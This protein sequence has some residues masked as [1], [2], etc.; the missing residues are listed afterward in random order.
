[1]TEKKKQGSMEYNYIRK[2]FTFNG[3]RYEVT[4][5]TEKE[6]TRK[7][8]DKRASLEH[9]EAL[10]HGEMLLKDWALVAFETF[11]PNI[12]PGS[13]QQIKYRFDKHVISQIGDMRLSRIRPIDCQKIMNAQAGKSKNHIDRVAQELFFVFDCARKNGMISENPAADLAKPQGYKNLRR[14]M[15][16]EERKHFLL[17]AEKVPRFILFELMLYCGCRPME[18][19]GV[20]FEDISRR[21]GVP[22][23]HIRGTKTA[24]SDRF[25]PLPKELQG[26]LCKRDSRGPC[27]LTGRGTMYNDTSYKRLVKRLRREMNISMGA[28]LYRNALVPPLPLADDFVPYILRH[29]YCCDLKKKGIDIRIA[30]QLMGHADI[31]TT[32]NIYD[33]A[34]DESL[35]TAARKMGL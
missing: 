5:K 15:T 29:T 20:C 19:A 25:V 31:R 24:N 4:G 12:T 14:A 13:A 35:M 7:L 34:D 16:D 10:R 21:D 22:F 1:M 33:H 11:K 6:A 2:T 23:L 8:L 32:A 9:E 3:K 26:R 27:V 30:K 18:A 17:A 28:K